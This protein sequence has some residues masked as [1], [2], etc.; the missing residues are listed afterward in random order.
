M[1]LGP[2]VPVGN[3]R[4]TQVRRGRSILLPA[5]TGCSDAAAFSAARA[6]G[7]G[8]GKRSPSRRGGAPRP[9][10]GRR[11]ARPPAPARGSAP[12]RQPVEP[13][14][15]IDPGGGDERVTRWNV[16]PLAIGALIRCRPRDRRAGRRLTRPGAA[17]EIKAVDVPAA[18][19]PDHPG[20]GRARRQTRAARADARGAPPR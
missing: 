15:L 8:L 18:R 20:G 10:P 16:L 12:L 9:A 13:D 11:P 3:G 2:E 14:T 19:P 7:A 6:T 17:G 1:G 4:L 5:A